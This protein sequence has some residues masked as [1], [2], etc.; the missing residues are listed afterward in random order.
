MYHQGFSAEVHCR[1]Q[2]FFDAVGVYPSAVVYTSVT[3]GYSSTTSN[4]TVPTDYNIQ[5]S[6]SDGYILGDGYLI[7][8]VCKYQDFE[9]ATNQSF[10]VLMQGH[11]EGI[12]PTICEVSPRITL[13]DIGFDGSTVNIQNTT[14]SQPLSPDGQEAVYIDFISDFIWMMMFDAQS[15][16]GNFMAEGIHS[17]SNDTLTGTLF[18]D[19]LENY[20]RGSI[21]LF[22]TASRQMWRQDFQENDPP[23]SDYN[24]TIHVRS[25]GY[26]YRGSTYL[27]LLGPLAL[28]VFAT[29]GAAIY[30]P[31]AQP[32]KPVDVSLVEDGMMQEMM[33]GPL[34]SL[35]DSEDF[36]PTNII[37]LMMAASRIR[38]NR[39]VGENEL[40]QIHLDSTRSNIPE[41]RMAQLQ[42]DDEEIF[43][44]QNSHRLR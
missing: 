32:K 22:G 25:L 37:H 39:E 28:V 3:P 29:F 27:V 1:Q 15:I 8:S 17:V 20:L 36:D 23:V 21:E 12:E 33:D 31:V 14:D 6:T 40:L 7:S 11:E 10:L 2:P 19:L 41:T 4:Q 13:V 5:N 35:G 38:L 34:G 26:Q 18:N 43:M 44:V 9:K 30:A 24:G 42:E 16:S